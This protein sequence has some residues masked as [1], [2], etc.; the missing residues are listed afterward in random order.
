MKILVPC[1]LLLAGAGLMHA[2]IVEALSFDLSHLHAGSTLSGTFTLNDAPMVGETAS[3][4]LSF[5]DPSDYSSTAL[6]TTITIESGTPSGFAVQF[7]ELTFTNLSGTTSPIDTKDVDLTGYAFAHCASFPCTASG[8]V[9]DRSPAVFTSTYTI[10]PVTVPEP[11]YAPLV[12]FLLTA[13]VFGRRLVRPG[14]P[15]YGH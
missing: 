10:T 7:S 12:P 4:S 2:S 5:S 14:P 3:V 1:V 8:G 13:V 9:D 6:T 11:G 15:P